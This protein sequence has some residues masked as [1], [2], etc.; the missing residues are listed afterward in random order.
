MEGFRYLNVRLVSSYN[1][2]D[3][4]LGIKRVSWSPSGQ[5]LAIGSYDQ[6]CRLLNYYTWKPLIEFAHPKQLT[7]TD[8]V[9]YK[10]IDHCSSK[11]APSW[12]S[13]SRS[14]IQ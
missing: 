7:P 10:E 4:G 8:I 5:F 2:Y 1:A 6:K 13:N 12:Q 9:V 11:D 3:D 14:K